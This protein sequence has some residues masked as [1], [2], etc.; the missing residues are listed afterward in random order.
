MKVYIVFTGSYS[1]KHISGVFLKKEQAE[2]LITAMDNSC[3][4]FIPPR[5]IEVYDTGISCKLL[6]KE[7][8]AYDVKMGINNGKIAVSEIDKL[9]EYS[10]L[11]MY[12]N[13]GDFGD[14][15]SAYVLAKSRTHAMK[16]AYNKFVKCKYRKVMRG[17]PMPNVQ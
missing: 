17:E 10:D 6:D 9:D 3:E 8:K 2:Q 14:L 7:Y 5:K 11:Q 1:D 16:I 15:Y 13:V 12:N 4:D